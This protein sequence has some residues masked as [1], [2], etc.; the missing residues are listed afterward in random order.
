MFCCGLVA[1][2]F[3]EFI[4]FEVGSIYYWLS[5]RYRARQQQT[6]RLQSRN[7]PYLRNRRKGE[8][9]KEKGHHY[10]CR[11]HRLP[12]S[13]RVVVSEAE[14]PACTR[15]RY[16]IFS[17]FSL[18]SVFAQRT[19]RRGNRISYVISCDNWTIDGHLRRPPGRRR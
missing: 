7:M 11:V 9:L 19:N 2:L 13:I 4:F 16:S 14:L 5:Y 3:V 15:T 1:T 6:R 8:S 10:H 17:P 18:S 12:T